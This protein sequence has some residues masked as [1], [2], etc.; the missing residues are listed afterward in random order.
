MSF[1]EETIMILQQF[2]E[3]N[4][5]YFRDYARTHYKST[6]EIILTAKAMDFI[7]GLV[8]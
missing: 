3:G 1:D 8:E 6:E 7:E 5:P 2:A 4:H